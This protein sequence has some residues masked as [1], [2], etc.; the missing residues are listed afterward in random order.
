MSIIKKYRAISAVNSLVKLEKY[1]EAQKK[2]MELMEEYPEDVE[3]TLCLASL[4]HS[5]GDMNE[6]KPVV[7]A[8][9]GMDPSNDSALNLMGSFHLRKKELNKAE[10]YFKEALANASEEAIYYGNLGLIYLQRKAYNQAIDI[11]EEGMKYDPENEHCLHVIY[12]A[13]EGL[14]LPYKAEAVL[15]RI[16][17]KNPENRTALINLGYSYYGKD[18]LDK[19]QSIFKSVMTMRGD[20]DDALRG[21][22]RTALLQHSISRVL[23]SDGLKKSIR[24]FTFI[25]GFLSGVASISGHEV[26]IYIHEVFIFGLAQILI[27]QF[28]DL[29]FTTGWFYLTDKTKRHLFNKIELGNSLTAMITYFGFVIILLSLVVLWSQGLDYNRIWVLVAFYLMVL[30]FMFSMRCRFEDFHIHLRRLSL[31]V[32]IGLMAGSLYSMEEKWLC[33]VGLL[34]MFI[35]DLKLMNWI[36]EN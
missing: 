36:T 3:V 11:A 30:S 17:K 20:Q 7:Q 13:Y 35:L 2:V 26:P 23:E 1:E 10:S 4:L 8:V 15:N 29:P 19:A 9:L 34:P 25:L 32:M 24:V 22:K 21:I 33:F 28:L 31:L 27:I 6:A 5:K 18:R 14:G 12:R 16:L